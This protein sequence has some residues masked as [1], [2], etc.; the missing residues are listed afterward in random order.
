MTTGT[1]L[2][3]ARTLTTARYELHGN[4]AADLAEQLLTLHPP[5]SSRRFV[6]YPVPGTSRFADL[7]RQ[8]ELEVFGDVFGNDL[9][10][11]VAEYGPYEQASVFLVVM[12]QRRRRAAGV[13]RMIENS[14]TG[15]K[16]LNDVAGEPLRLPQAQVRAHHGITDLDRVWD[17]GTLAVRPEYRRS[18]TRR[19]NVSLLLYRA[20]YVYALRAGMEHVVTAIDSH[21]HRAMLALGVPFVPICDSEP[22][23]YIGSPCTALYGHLP[24]FQSK[25]EE[26]SRRLRTRRPLAWFLLAGPMRK[27]ARGRGM[28]ERLQPP[29]E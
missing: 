19:R 18:G 2:D 27:I 9:A 28:D 13:F 17:V 26:R 10:E 12:D 16:T 29:V 8:V 25:V 14:A 4:V 11:L 15:L 3:D 1:G 24:E 7:G 20:F 23:D 22:F 21:A 6:C 5:T